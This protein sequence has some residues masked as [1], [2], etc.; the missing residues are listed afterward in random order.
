MV[1]FSHNDKYIIEFV[2]AHQRPVPQAAEG[3]DQLNFHAV[4]SVRPELGQS[5][6]E[7]QPVSLSCR[8]IPELR[9]QIHGCVSQVRIYL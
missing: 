3:Q 9:S 7:S 2:V 5:H 6:F 1:F 4:E 8:R